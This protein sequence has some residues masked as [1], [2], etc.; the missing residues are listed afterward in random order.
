MVKQ[1]EHRR[2]R[3]TFSREFKAEAVR[4]CSLG[5]RSTGQLATDLDLT[6]TALRDWLVAFE[7]PQAC[8]GVAF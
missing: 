5:D 2:K 4:L 8:R 6:E 3:G 7:D 1:R